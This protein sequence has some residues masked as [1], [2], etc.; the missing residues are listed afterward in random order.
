MAGVAGRM[1]A[2]FHMTSHSLVGFVSACSCGGGRAPAAGKA[3]PLTLIRL[4]F[5]W[6]SHSQF[7]IQGVA[8]WTL[9]LDGR[10]SK[11]TL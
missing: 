3:S 5:L 6:P 4:T 7:Q 2:S 9:S 10:N 8:K 11:A 1:K